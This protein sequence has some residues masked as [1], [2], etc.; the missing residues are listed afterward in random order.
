MRKIPNFSSPIQN[1]KTTSKLLTHKSRF[2]SPG[3]TKSVSTQRLFEE[4]FIIGVEYNDIKK[5]DWNK[6]PT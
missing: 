1:N 6:C 5:L 2:E 3:I 4:F